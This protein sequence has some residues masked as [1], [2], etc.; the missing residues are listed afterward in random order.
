MF[1]N[2]AFTAIPIIWFAVFDW[3]FDKQTLLDNPSLYRIGLDDLFFDRTTFWRWFMYA[4]WQGTLLLFIS[5]DTLQ[6]YTDGLWQMGEFEV[7]GNFIFCV[8]VILVNIKLLISSFEQTFGIW[9]WCIG[10]LALF[11]PAYALQC[12]YGPYPSNG[13]F[14]HTFQDGQVYMLILF[15]CAA[16]ILIDVGISMTNAEIRYYMFIHNVIKRRL[17][18]NKAK[19]D[20]T[21]VSKHIQKYQN[22]GFAFAQEKGNDVLLMDTLENRVANAMKAKLFATTLQMNGG[23]NTDH[24]SAPKESEL[25]AGD[26]AAADE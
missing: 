1:Y 7:Q 13:A 2:V 22:R 8:L 16:F 24:F 9:F 26:D 12:A 15:F 25:P 17:A 6:G 5:Y 10:S 23:L 18:K 19:K 4:V 21:Q 3:E 11:F 20:R 14:T